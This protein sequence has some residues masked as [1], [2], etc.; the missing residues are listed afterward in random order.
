MAETTLT[1]RRRV[2]DDERLGGLEPSSPGWVIGFPAI[3]P[4]VYAEE[5]IC[6]HEIPSRELKLQAIRIGELGIA[7]IPNEVFALT[8]LKIKAR[9]PLPLTMNI[10]LANGSEGYIPPPEQHVLGGYTTWPARTAALEVQA[11][12]RIVETVLGPAGTGRGP[13]AP[14]VARH[15]HPTPSMSWPP[16][17]WP[18]GGSTRWRDQRALDATGREHE[19]R[20]ENG[21]AFFLPGPDLPGL[22]DGGRISRAACAGDAEEMAEPAGIGRPGHECDLGLDGLEPLLH[23]ADEVLHAAVGPVLVPAERRVVHV[24]GRDLGPCCLLR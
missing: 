24:G 14:D 3:F 9:S 12:P 8:G 2:P 13:A 1:L 16:G 11:E 15:G 21:I 22:R 5:A 20:Y 17:P 10:E 4:E 18:T 7:A 23:P 19:I 6:L